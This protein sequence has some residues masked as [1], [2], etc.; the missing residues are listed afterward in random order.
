GRTPDAPD[1]HLSTRPPSPACGCWAAAPA[2]LKMRSAA[3]NDPKAAKR[4]CTSASAGSPDGFP[5]ASTTS[6][7]EDHSVSMDRMLSDQSHHRQH[8]CLPGYHKLASELA[9]E[10][11]WITRSTRVPILLGDSD[12]SS[13]ANLW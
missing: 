11:P 8:T 6:R 10:S 12:A 3:C 1:Q 5:K 4:P 7:P 13:D 2:Y 9:S